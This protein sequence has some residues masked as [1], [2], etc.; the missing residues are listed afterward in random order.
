M[1]LICI[2][3]L[4][5]NTS[6][7]LWPLTFKRIHD[8]FSCK[9]RFFLEKHF[10]FVASPSSSCIEY[11]EIAMPYKLI[12]VSMVMTA[13]GELTTHTTVTCRCTCMTRLELY[14]HWPVNVVKTS[15]CWCPIVMCLFVNLYRAK[16]LSFL[17][18]GTQALPIKYLCVEDVKRPTT[19]FLDQKLR[20]KIL[21]KSLSRSYSLCPHWFYRIGTIHA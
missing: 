6:Q 21:S 10:V 14:F 16:V 8:C 12:D 13:S 1:Y 9:Q 5:Y 2:K 15:L 17:S 19:C 4:Y 3:K 11:T 7:H 20:L 18:I